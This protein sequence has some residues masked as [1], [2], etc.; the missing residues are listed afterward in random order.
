[1]TSSKLDQIT[2]HRPA[3]AAAAAAAVVLTAMLTQVKPLTQL[4]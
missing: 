2:Q 1:M 4:L 3:A